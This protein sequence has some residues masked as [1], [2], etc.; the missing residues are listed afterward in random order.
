MNNLSV[1]KY[2]QQQRKSVGLTQQQLAEKLNISFQA[3]SKWENGETYPDVTLLLPLADILQTTTDKIL[4]GGVWTLNQHKRITLQDIYEGINAFCTIKRTLHQTMFY[5]SAISGI[6][7]AMNFDMEAS[8]STEQGKQVL[9]TEAIL[10]SIMSG[11][12]VEIERLEELITEPKL[13]EQINK[14][15]KKLCLD[16]AS[17]NNL[18]ITK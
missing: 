13:V 8:L 10:Q 2:I 16:A 11:C 17:Q 3:V 7:N 12:Y 14:T 5:T 18:T 15:I 6:N 9:Y 4:S 1:G